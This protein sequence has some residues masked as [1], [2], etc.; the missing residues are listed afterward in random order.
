MLQQR[1]DG[2]VLAGKLSFSQYSV[3]LAMTDAMHQSC[4][5]PTFALWDQVVCIPLRRWYV[6]TAKWTHNTRQ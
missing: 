4:L 1:L 2:G 5:P 6:T 3:N